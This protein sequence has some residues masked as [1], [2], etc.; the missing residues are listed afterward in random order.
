MKNNDISSSH[1][2]NHCRQS[3]KSFCNYC[4]HLGHSIEICYRHRQSNKRFCNF[5]KHLGHTIET[6]YYCNKSTAPIAA[7]A[8]TENI[9]P[10]TPILAKSKFF[11][12][13][14]TI[15]IVD[16]QNIIANTILMVGNAS[17]SFSL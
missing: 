6:C 5:C 15:S 8:N 13:T 4:K 11:G 9:Q 12:S 2:N 7:I 14:I 16:L 3:N 1:C 10:M 17:F